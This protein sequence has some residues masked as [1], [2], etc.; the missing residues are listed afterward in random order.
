MNLVSRIHHIATAASDLDATVAFYDEVFGLTPNPGFPME[1]PVGRIAFYSIGGVEM[2]IVE[3]PVDPAPTETPAILLQSNLRLDHFTLAVDSQEAFDT[4]RERLV[5]RGAS[6]GTLT[7][8]GDASLL[9]YSD[10]DGHRMEVIYQP[11]G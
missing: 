9:A 11:G 1:S 8:F 7:P 10:P 2:Q 4:I 5:E 6:D 3:A